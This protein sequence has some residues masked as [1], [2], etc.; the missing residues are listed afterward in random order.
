MVHFRIGEIQNWEAFGR[1]YRSYDV[2]HFHRLLFGLS[3]PGISLAEDTSLT[4]LWTILP[5]FAMRF[6]GLAI[7]GST[8][9]KTIDPQRGP[10]KIGTDPSCGLRQPEH[11]FIYCVPTECL[12][13]RLSLVDYG[14]FLCSNV[15]TRG[16]DSISTVISPQVLSRAEN[17][18][19]YW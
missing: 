14:S 8:F 17:K 18:P 1:D 6:L 13:S 3:P 15:G 16:W 9:C 4:E 11:V 5:P 2:A 7:L 10:G 19:N 12:A